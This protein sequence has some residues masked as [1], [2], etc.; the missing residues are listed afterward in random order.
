MCKTMLWLQL[1][2]KA[3]QSYLHPSLSPQEHPFY[4]GAQFHPEFKSRPNRPSPPFFAF[5]SAALSRKDEQEHHT[6]ARMATSSKTNKSSKGGSGG[7][8]A[9]MSA[10]LGG[11]HDFPSKSNGRVLGA[12][13]R[14]LSKAGTSQ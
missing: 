12:K 8:S 14:Q 6:S 2:H 4:F 5:V 13:K 7:S 11:V 9:G 10:I 3:Q 1:A